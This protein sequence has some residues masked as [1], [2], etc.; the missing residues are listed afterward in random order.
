[1]PFQIYL[2]NHLEVSSVRMTFEIPNSKLQIPNK[3]QCPI[4]N[5][6][7]NLF[8]ILDLLIGVY[9]VLSRESFL[10]SNR[11]GIY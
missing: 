1:M 6:Q 9:L 10:L 3:F 2:S 7:I 8:V 5:N 11:Y 4:C